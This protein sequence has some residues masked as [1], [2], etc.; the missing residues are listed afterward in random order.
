M[1]VDTTHLAARAMQHWER[2]LPQKTADLKEAG[3][4][5]MRANQAAERA[6]AEIGQLV[7]AGMRQDEAEEMVLPEYILLQP[8]RGV[9]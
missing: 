9:E 5:E 3:T 2:W 7:Q 8:E 4:F 6:Q 1:N